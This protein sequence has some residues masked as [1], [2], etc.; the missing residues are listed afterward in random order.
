MEGMDAKTCKSVRSARCAMGWT[1]GN[2]I[3]GNQSIN[4]VFEVATNY[5]DYARTKLGL[6]GPSPVNFRLRSTF[7]FGG[8]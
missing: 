1:P 5:D 7:W 6:R 2:G 4:H 8:S 3:E